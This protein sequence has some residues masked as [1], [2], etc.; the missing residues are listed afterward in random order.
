MNEVKLPQTSEEDL[1]SVVIFWHKSE[2]DAVN[3]GDVLVEV[4][5]EKAVFEIEAEE[6]GILN[7]IL[8]QR[9]EVAGVGDIL[10]TISSPAE[11]AVNR[12]HNDLINKEQLQAA[13]D[14]QGETQFVRVSPRI[15]KLARDLGVD[16]ASVKGSGRNG[17][18]TE[19]D[20]QNAAKEKLSDYRVLAFNGVR[21]TISRR[22]SDSLQTSAQLTQTAWADVS[23]LDQERNRMQ[24]SITWNDILV[25]AVTKSLQIHKHINAHVFEEEIHQ[26]QQVH[27]GIA[28]DTQEGLF[29]PVIK[30]ADEF[31]L[32]QLKDQVHRLIQKAKENKLSTDEMSGGTFTITNL[33]SFGIE[34]FTPIINR[35]EAAILGAGKIVTDLVLKE[36]EVTERKK[37]PLS[38]TFDHRAIDGVPAAKFLQTVIAYLQEPSKLL[39][40]VLAK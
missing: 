40:E 18:H 9:G 24:E 13:P 15:R 14:N 11:N 17:Q 12:E 33:G 38:L 39:D 26:Y 19:Q 2:G 6:S 1:E 3:E 31:N 16:L 5:T 27:L 28:V 30:K 35:P 4:Q 37:L 23:L 34:F 8:V 20:I 25:F 7:E 36:G 21:K 29:V 22:M 32:I 10:A